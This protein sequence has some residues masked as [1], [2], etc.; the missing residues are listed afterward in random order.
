MVGLLQVLWGR[1]DGTFKA[2]EELK[3]TDG[4]LHA[5]EVLIFPEAMKGTGEGHRPW[6]LQP[7]SQMTNA[8]VSGGTE[9]TRYFA[10]GLVRHEGG[11]IYNT[12][13]DKQSVRLN[14]DQDIGR[15]IKFSMATNVVHTATD[16]RVRRPVGGW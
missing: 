14:L 7:E 4:K 12:F 13:A 5:L 11:T 3:G 6:D 8:T 15:R 2:A 10:S 16:R 9:T 1:S